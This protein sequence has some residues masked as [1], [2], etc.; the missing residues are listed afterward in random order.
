MVCVSVCVPGCLQ[1]CRHPLGD[2]AAAQQ[3]LLKRIPNLQ[4]GFYDWESFN[5]VPRFD[6]FLK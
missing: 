5:L 1:L 6:E 4:K 3:K 2:V